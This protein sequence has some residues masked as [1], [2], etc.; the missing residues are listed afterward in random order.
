MAPG[1]VYL[2]SGGE[3]GKPSLTCEGDP[4]GEDRAFIH[5]PPPG[6]E[7]DHRGH[8]DLMPGEGVHRRAS[9]GEPPVATRSRIENK[10]RCVPT[11]VGDGECNR[12]GD[13]RPASG[14][15]LQRRRCGG[16]S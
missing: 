10:L 1:A 7:D 15:Q 9:V 6:I 14:R 11:T 12:G 16:L 8:V 2:T 3:D 13:W 5:L 4:A